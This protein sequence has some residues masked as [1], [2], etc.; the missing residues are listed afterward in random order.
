MPSS[1]DTID[2]LG[3]ILEE[4]KMIFAILVIVSL[5][6]IVGIIHLSVDCN[7]TKNNARRKRSLC[8]DDEDDHLIKQIISYNNAINEL[9]K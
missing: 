7:Q 5:L 6:L 2:V 8:N 1:E 4:E 9:K 3:I